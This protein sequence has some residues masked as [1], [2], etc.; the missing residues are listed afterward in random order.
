MKRD[1][2]LNKNKRLLKALL[3]RWLFAFVGI[4]FLFCEAIYAA[5][6]PIDPA[7]QLEREA[8]Q[9]SVR[10]ELSRIPERV[11]IPE[12]KGMRFKPFKG[13]L[14]IKNIKITGNNLLRN[15]LRSKEREYLSPYLNHCVDSAKL[16]DLII[17]LNTILFD[18]GYITTRIEIDN[19]NKNTNE[20]TIKIQEGK[21]ENIEANSI[22]YHTVFPS[23]IGKELKAQDLEQGLEQLNRLPSQASIITLWP[24]KEVGGTTVKV[25][26]KKVGKPYRFYLM[27]DN[28]GN[29]RTGQNVL[30]G[31]FSVDD[32]FHLNDQL[33]L[34]GLKSG[35]GRDHSVAFTWKEE[36]PLGYY[37][38]GYSGSYSD[39]QYDIY[40]GIKD[41]ELATSSFKNKLNLSRTVYRSL[42][43]HISLGTSF[44]HYA[45]CRE[46]AGRSSFD[47][48]KLSVFEL[49]V[50]H[51][52]YRPIFRILTELSYAQGIKF[53]GATEDSS[54][55]GLGASHSQ[56]KRYSLI[57]DYLWRVSD[58]TRLNGNLQ[59]QYAEQGLPGVVKLPVLDEI[60]GIRGLKSNGLTCD[61][62]II[63]R[64]DIVFPLSFSSIAQNKIMK[65]VVISPF[66]HGDIGWAKDKGTKLEQI[67]AVGGGIKLN[68][69]GFNG[70][71]TLSKLID[72]PSEAKGNGWVCLFELSQK[73]L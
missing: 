50:H 42:N 22:N 60:G 41:S 55:L 57:S 46:I 6:H 39:S 30:K 56:F 51:D 5:E 54:S 32:L 26:T 68:L 35:L 28:M 62:G 65:E 40:P 49:S 20:L 23:L 38:M 3:V 44:W 31:S 12:D 67:S 64:H 19:Y 73:L 14:L 70:Q 48:K 63:L 69:L 53:L 29:K 4:Y 58:K 61:D 25:D 13:C 18:K 11:R 52:Y 9:K 37:T 16:N 17:K 43:N 27:F 59:L 10:E 1:L 15:L 71:I 36:V 72:K 34:S 33:S 45:P 8:R 66:L 2:D 7:E 47:D 24:G 21:I